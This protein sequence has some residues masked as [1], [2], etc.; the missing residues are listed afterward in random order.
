MTQ[1]VEL[2][3]VLPELEAAGYC[4][5]AISYDTQEQLRT[6]ADKH[7]ISYP[8]LSDIG[9]VVIKR[10]GILNTLISPDEAG[11]R[12]YGIPFP[13]TYVTD[14]SGVVVRKFFNQHH[15]VRE[16]GETLRDQ[17][18]GRISETA[19]STRATLSDDDIDVTVF[20]REPSFKLEIVS[21]IYCRIKLPKG[22]HIYAEPVPEGFVATRVEIA[23]TLGLRIGSISFPPS[24][25]LKMP[26]LRMR[27]NVYTETVDIGV[28]ISL[29]SKLVKLGH[30][31]E[32]DSVAMDVKVSYQACDDATCIQP[33]ELRVRFDA[34]NRR[35]DRP[36]RHT[37]ICRACVEGLTN[38][39]AQFESET[40]AS[41]VA[42]LHLRD[43]LIRTKVVSSGSID[44]TAGFD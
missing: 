11:Q 6:F 8:L 29:T 25:E 39:R 26:A 4:L 40:R 2:R 32:V 34:P 23:P 1:L 37:G 38:D 22:L 41:R 44:P 36:G 13:G 7:G 14:E 24:E 21:T 35:C 31:R 3:R 42:L 20:F 9:S 27:F 15:A 17:L 28:P 33:R 18:L 16:S 12:W 43:Y 30:A 10:Y 19:A 5:H